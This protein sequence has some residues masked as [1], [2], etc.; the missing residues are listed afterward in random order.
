MIKLRAATEKK[1][2]FLKIKGRSL[3]SECHNN[4]N[5]TLAQGAEVKWR[6]PVCWLDEGAQRSSEEVN[7]GEETEGVRLGP[8]FQSRLESDKYA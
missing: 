6:Q 5:V 4:E 7:G 8:G 3:K 2:L 1:T